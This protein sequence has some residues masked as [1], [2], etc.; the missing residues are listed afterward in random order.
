[1]KKWWKKYNGFVAFIL[2]LVVVA[3]IYAYR[4]YTRTLPDTNEL[5]AAYHFK[6][7]DLLRQFETD[8]GKATAE[9][10]DKVISVQGTISL[11]QATD[12]SGT[13]FLNDG[14]SVASVMCQFDQ[15]NFKEMLELQKGDAITIKG[16]CSGYLMDVVM[17]R[18]VIEQ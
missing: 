10:S 13:V 6:I 9:Y 18:C 12:S 7:A 4:E 16:V 15:K 14:S 2:C 8:E 11:V 1:M 17:V 5:K 3:G